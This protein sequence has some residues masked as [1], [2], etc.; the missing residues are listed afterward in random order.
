VRIR[1]VLPAGLHLSVAVVFALGGFACDAEDDDDDEGEHGG[2]VETV[3]TDVCSTG[4]RWAGGDEESS[5]MHPGGDCIGCHTD[6]G[7]GPRYLAAGTVHLRLDEPD[8]CFGVEGATVEITDA[9]GEQWAQLTNAAGNFYVERDEGPIAMPFTAK[10]IV[11]GV[12]RVMATPQTDANC[13]TCHTAGGANL[14][15]GRIVP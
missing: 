8:D 13:A 5:R 6:R 14:A 2:L 11:D 7:E 1:D 15:A 4:Q 10:V 9:N 3:S 12:E